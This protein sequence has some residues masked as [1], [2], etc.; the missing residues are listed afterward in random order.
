M[1]Q[2]Y[3]E[4]EVFQF[5]YGGLRPTQEINKGSVNFD[6]SQCYI[7]TGETLTYEVMQPSVLTNVALSEFGIPNI[8]G[9]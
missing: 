8:L 3:E 2:L 7:M 9:Q 5:Q 4:S 6:V 1:Q